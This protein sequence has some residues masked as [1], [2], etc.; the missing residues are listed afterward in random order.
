MRSLKKAKSTFPLILLLSVGGVCA[1]VQ[2]AKW[3]KETFYDPAKGSYSMATDLK[4]APE[5]EQIVGRSVYTSNNFVAAQVAKKVLAA[6]IESGGTTFTIYRFN[7]PQTC[8]KLGCLHVVVDERDKYTNSVQLIDLP[9]KSFPFTKLA[10]AGCFSVRQPSNGAI[11]N[12]EI[13]KPS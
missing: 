9:D 2:L 13:C 8:G 5:I 12:Y 6:Q 3:V 11:D 7:L 4:S 1:L 10:K